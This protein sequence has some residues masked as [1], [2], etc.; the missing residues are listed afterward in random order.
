MDLYLAHE[1]SLK[2]LRYARAEKDLTLIPVKGF[3]CDASQLVIDPALLASAL[4]EGLF[5]VSRRRPLSLRFPGEARRSQSSLVRASPNLDRLPPQAY[6]EVVTSQGNPIYTSDGNV[7]HAYVESAGLALT[8]AARSLLAMARQERITER[9]ALI[10][11][12]AFAMELCG[13]YARLPDR[14]TSEVT[15]DLA[16]VGTIE[17]ITE[18]LAN[19]KGLHGSLLARRAASYA[20]DGSGSP[21]ETLWFFLFCMPPRLGGIHLARPQ[22]NVAINWPEGIRELACHNILTPD[23]HWPEYRRVCEYDSELHKSDQAFY[24]DRNR[25]KDYELCNL[26]YFPITDLDTKSGDSIKAFLRQL[27]KSI[28]PFESSPFRRRMHRILND[29]KVDSAREVLRGVLMP[30]PPQWRQDA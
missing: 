16:P 14:A 23:F 9:A 20:N 30:P 27:V 22:Q 5:D 3:L 15:Y 28:E 11:L 19:L 13:S 10:R 12:S 21:M 17:K 18:L 2:L 4:P 6:L 7:V 25:A 1:D 29:P 26:G 8:S 24:E